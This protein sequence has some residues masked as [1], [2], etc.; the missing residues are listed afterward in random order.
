ME[1]PQP[2]PL[3]PNPGQSGKEFLG[4]FLKFMGLMLT[5]GGSLAMIRAMAESVDSDTLRA[6][7]CV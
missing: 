1:S 5:L 7:T 2:N 6:T 3:L 4:Q